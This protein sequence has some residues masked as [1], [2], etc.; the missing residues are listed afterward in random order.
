[1]S[2]AAYP[3]AITF[4]ASAP[5]DKQP[6]KPQGDGSTVVLLDVPYPVS[7]DVEVFWKRS[8]GKYL[9]VLVQIEEPGDPVSR[10]GG[11]E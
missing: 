10:V 3:H 2:E 7:A 6:Y 4:V 9:R 1:M 11:S 8:Q 5:T